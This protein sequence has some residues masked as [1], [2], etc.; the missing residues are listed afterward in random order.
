VGRALPVL[1]IAVLLGGC[2][3]DGGRLSQEEYVAEG[4]EICAKYEAE[5]EA[6]AEP[7]SLAGFGDFVDR[8]KPILERQLADF[9][10]L[11]P[12]EELQDRHDEALAVQEEGIR[13][14]DGLKEA[15]A[16]ED[17][18]AFQEAVDEIERIDGESERVALEL[19]L[20]GCASDE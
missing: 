9:R 4:E 12:P 17:E 6:L 8:A 7:Q 19:G 11:E 5:G 20:D 10:A 3:G 18:A 2:G 13:V 16:A 14:L 1:A 15:A